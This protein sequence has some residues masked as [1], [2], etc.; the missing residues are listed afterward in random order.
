MPESWKITL[1]CTRAEAE[2]LAEQ[3]LF[4]ISA[5]M[6]LSIVTREVD[7]A[8]PDAWV[9]DIYT[10]SQ[11]TKDQLARLAKLSPSALTRKVKPQVEKLPDEDWVSLSQQGLEPL[12]A[13]R[14]HV[15]T[16]ND[17]PLSDPE[18]V[19]LQIDA[20]QAF[21]TGH[22]ETTLG[23][24]T[25]LDLLK[26]RGRHYRNIIDVGTGTGLLAMAARHLWPVARI[27]ASDV[28][29]VAVE[30]CK[31][32]AALNGLETGCSRHGITMVA[33][34]GLDH[35]AIRQRAPYDLIIANILARPLIGLAPQVAAAAAPG[36]TLILAGLLTEQQEELVGAYRHNGFRLVES[37]KQ[38]QWPC[39]VLQRRRDHRSSRPLS[40]I[41]SP[42]PE[43]YFGE[44]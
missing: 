16:G 20:G 39:L 4:E 33:S 6:G 31:R 27:M 3:E 25:T 37:R 44:W 36:S 24:L 21:G 41:R 42:L 14:F 18:V 10:D 22:H 11:P 2:I 23:C 13:G 12:R 28:D 29:P 43:T 7:A 19:N 38:D 8:Q 1:P 26:R 32:N 35:R 34:N 30:V 40:Q 9:I 5:D 17:A 15:H